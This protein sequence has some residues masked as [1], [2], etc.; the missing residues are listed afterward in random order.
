MNSQQIKLNI[1]ISINQLID[2]VKQLSPK[3]KFLL[4][5]VLWDETEDIDIEIPEEHKQTVRKRLQRMEEQPGSCFTWK[6]IERK[7]EL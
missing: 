2:I 7:I 5:N 6:E 4:S 1:P 3:E